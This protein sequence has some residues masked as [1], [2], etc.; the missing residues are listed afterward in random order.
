MFAPNTN[1]ASTTQKTLHALAPFDSVIVAPAPALN[2]API[3]NKKTASG[4][5]WPSKVRFS[6]NATA[7]R[8]E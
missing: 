6:N 2:A 1:A 8:I 7:E 3:L 5:F 4:L